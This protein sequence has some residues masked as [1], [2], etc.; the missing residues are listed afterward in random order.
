MTRWQD[1]PSQAMR[2]FDRHRDGF[3][4]GEGAAFV[5]L[6]ELGHAVARRARIYAEVLGHGQSSEGVDA[7]PV[8]REGRG[9][10]GAMERALAEARLHPGEID[11]VNAHGSATEA[12][13][14]AETD[15]LKEVFG[16]WTSRVAVSSTKPVTGHL[17]GAAGA[18]ETVVCALA[19][20]RG[21]IPPTLN[22]AMAGDGCDL[23]YVPKRCRPYPV[24]HALNLS[25][26]FEG[27]DA[28]LVLGR[29]RE[30]A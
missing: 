11:Y 22:H 25:S 29:Y 28:C 15:A 27:K 16:R 17:L 12:G 7:A 26:G 6:E 19:I 1:K 14:L 2:P 3:V 21:A 13:D 18:L 8:L 23:D 5:V 30:G 9:L 10:A 20:A 24:R 4:L